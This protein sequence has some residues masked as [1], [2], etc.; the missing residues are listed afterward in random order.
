[1]NVVVSEFTLLPPVDLVVI[2]TEQEQSEDYGYDLELEGFEWSEPRDTNVGCLET[3]TQSSQC[4]I[5][6]GTLFCS[7]Y[8]F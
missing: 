8:S 6:G 4:A 7:K 1:M 3:E 5:P 2:V